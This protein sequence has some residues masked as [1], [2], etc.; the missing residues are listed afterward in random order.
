MWLVC[1]IA[2]FLSW[3]IADLFYKIGNQSSEEANHLK[4]GILVGLIMGIHAT[5]FL[6]V[7]PTSITIM[8]VIKYLPVSLL[9]ISSMVI[10]YRGLKYLECVKTLSKLYVTCACDFAQ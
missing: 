9:Y 4:T 8:D 2:T 7:K 10:G 3:G 1:T 5:L 6:L